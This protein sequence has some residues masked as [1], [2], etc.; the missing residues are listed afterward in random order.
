MKRIAIPLFFTASL[1]AC[2]SNACENT[3]EQICIKNEEIAATV[4]DVFDRMIYVEPGKFFMGFETGDAD[5]VPFREIH[6]DG[7]YLHNSEMLYS[8]IVAFDKYADWEREVTRAKYDPNSDVAHLTAGPDYPVGAVFPWRD[9]YAYCNWLGEVTGLEFNLPSEAQ[10]EKAAKGGEKFA[11]YGTPDGTKKIGVNLPSAEDRVIDGFTRTV[12]K[13]NEFPPNPWGFYGISHN[14]EEWMLDL[15]RSDWLHV[16]PG[17]N[18]VNAPSIEQ[19]ER[20]FN[21]QTYTDF[22]TRSDFYVTYIQNRRG[23]SSHSGQS[24]RCAINSDQPLPTMIIE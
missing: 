16:M 6:L 7:Y 13:Y 22:S 21:E 8:Q 19:I 11:M 14:G 10:W 24:F 1:T 15:Y 4:Q 12:L 9:A 3:A 5:E 17:E 23:T 18:P 2:Q 20:E